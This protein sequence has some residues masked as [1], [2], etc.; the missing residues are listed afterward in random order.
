MPTAIPRSGSFWALELSLQSHGLQ[1]VGIGIEDCLL[2]PELPLFMQPLPCLSL[3]Q[4]E[5]IWLHGVWQ[6]PER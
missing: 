4:P 1:G 6:F 3:M 2:Q 5:G